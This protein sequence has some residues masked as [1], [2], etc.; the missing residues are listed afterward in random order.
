MSREDKEK[1]KDDSEK[2]ASRLFGLVLIIIGLFI[3]FSVI[4][5]DSEGLKFIS[6]FIVVPALL[7]IG[8]IYVMDN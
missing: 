6:G 1:R 7:I 5:S 2:K 4:N 3:G 8:F